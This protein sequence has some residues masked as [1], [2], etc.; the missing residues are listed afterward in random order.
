MNEAAGPVVVVLDEQGGIEIDSGRWQ[1]L[2]SGALVSSGVVSGELNLIFVDEA[3][4]TRLNHEHMGNGYATDVLSFPIDGPATVE[5]SA[6]ES[7]ESLIGDVVV[8][9]AQAAVQARDHEGQRGHDGSLEDELALLIVHG[10]LHVL[11]H[12]HYDTATANRM[13]SCEQALLRRHHRA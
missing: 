7:G 11:G 8:C 9:P 2:A 12:D 1:R 3:T 10:V 5:S 13:Q 6:A 4:M